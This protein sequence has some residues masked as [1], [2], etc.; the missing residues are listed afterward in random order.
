MKSVILC[1][2]LCLALLTGCAASANE[3]PPVLD[4]DDQKAL[5]A[6][7]FALSQ[8]L[9]TLDLTP[10]EL[11][12]V[13]RGLSDGI[14]KVDE[15]FDIQAF[16]PQ[17][18]QIFDGRVRAKIEREKAAGLAL[19]EAAKAET[20]AK[21]LPSGAVYLETAAGTGA[22]PAITERVKLHYHGTF[23]NGDV[24]DSSV[25]AGEP[26]EFTLNQVV[27]CFGEGVSSMKVG[28]KAKLTCPPEAA[29][30]ESGRPGILPGTTL[31]FEVELLD[32][33]AAPAAPAVPSGNSDMGESPAE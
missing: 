28:G 24:F 31:I 6:V 33:L 7:G 4:T 22:Q 26:A 13:Q 18:E 17:L 19:V 32:I 29:Y 2:S 25:D 14:Q 9:T 8:N 27:P 16:M 11:T 5:Y 30:G 1:I 20:G 12:L 21:V 23:H 10:E 15:P 3:Q